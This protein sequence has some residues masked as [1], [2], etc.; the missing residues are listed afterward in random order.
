MK[1]KR[2]LCQKTPES[3]TII[4]LGALC[5]FAWEESPWTPPPLGASL[6]LA[7]RGGRPY[8]VGVS[9]G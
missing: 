3:S 5:A 6:L 7:V 9:G 8:A 4:L 1:V 2:I